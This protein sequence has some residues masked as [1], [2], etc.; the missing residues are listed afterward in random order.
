VRRVGGGRVSGDTRIIGCIW[1]GRSEGDSSC[2][3]P[4]KAQN[5]CHGGLHTYQFIIEHAGTVVNVAR[6]KGVA[7]RP[8]RRALVLQSSPP[9]CLDHS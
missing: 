5:G 3:A 7:T 2:S 8:G 9:V 4:L 1:R 6:T